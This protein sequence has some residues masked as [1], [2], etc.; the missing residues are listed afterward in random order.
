MPHAR[1]KVIPP[2]SVPA[3]L[4]SVNGLTRFHREGSKTVLPA[5]AMAK[6]SCRLVA[7]QDPGEVHEQLLA[8]LKAKAPAAVRW[9]VTP[10]A[11]SPAS[12]SE[13]E[14]KG[15]QALEK[16]METVWGKRPVFKREGG[17]VPVV[18]HFK[19]ILGVESVNTGFSMSA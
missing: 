1:N 5:W 8:Y 17:S 16:A 13:R 7:D 12:I 19:K 2:S 11:G 4:T 14:S 15:V 18:T 6:V 10:M 9:E 3:P